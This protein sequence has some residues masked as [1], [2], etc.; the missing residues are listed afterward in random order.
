MT[1]S[2][3]LRILGIGSTAVWAG[4]KIAIQKPIEGK[5]GHIQGLRIIEEPKYNKLRGIGRFNQEGLQVPVY[6]IDNRKNRQQR[7]R[8]I[9]LKLSKILTKPAVIG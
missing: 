8:H 6:E 1:R 7:K 4:I 9:F 5:I 2:A 3:F